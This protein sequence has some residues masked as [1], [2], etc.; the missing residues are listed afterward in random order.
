LVNKDARQPVA[1]EKRDEEEGERQKV[2]EKEDCTRRKRRA[3]M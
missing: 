2:L 1:G 3:A